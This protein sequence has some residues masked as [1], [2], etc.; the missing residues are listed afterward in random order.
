[1]NSKDAIGLARKE[2]RPPEDAY[3]RL[4]RRRDRKR[5]SARI[6]AGV[7][8]LAIATVAILTVLSAFA[9]PDR[10]A[11]PA[12]SCSLDVTHAWSGD[13]TGADSVGGLS[14]TLHGD[15]AFGAGLV[16]EAFELDGIDDFVSI[17]DAPSLDVGTEDFTVSLWVNFDA[18]EG[19]QILIE[20]WVQRSFEPEGVIGWTLTKLPDDHIGFAFA[21]G[22]SVD[23]RPLEI[24][25]G[26]W[27]HLAARRNGDTFQ[28]LMNGEVI[29][30]RTVPSGVVLD[31]DSPSSLKFG[32]R[33]S[34]TDTPGSISYQGAFL[35]GRI[36]EV[37]LIEGRAVS[38]GEI[39]E[40]VAAEAAGR[41]C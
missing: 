6:A 23:S 38:N 20:K 40:M 1:M 18:T 25:T 26:T 33:G 17:P 35:D 11:T 28:I 7:V 24:P 10:R 19:E 36:D 27:I 12:S 39:D 5:R 22:V 3:Q 31:L 2:L 21:E 13:G 41:R 30:S 32:H 14:A 4:L 34:P 29:G 9:E 8:G 16:G 37:K 15:A